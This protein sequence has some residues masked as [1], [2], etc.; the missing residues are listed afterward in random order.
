MS[1]GLVGFVT[2]VVVGVVWVAVVGAGSA[3]S[4]VGDVRLRRERSE[5]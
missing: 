5:S 2:D 4:C 1:V 3:T